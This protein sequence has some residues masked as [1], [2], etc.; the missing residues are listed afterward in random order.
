M[1]KFR[2]G[3]ADAAEMLELLSNYQVDERGC[4]IWQ[5][6]VDRNGYGR[7]YDPRRGRMYWVHIV[8][9][10]IHKGPVP[11]GHEVDHV[12]RTPQCMH[13]DHLEAVTKVE[14]A[15]RTFERLGRD[16]LH[17][18]AAELR[19]MNLTYREIGEVMGLAGKSS[20]AGMIKSAARKGLIREGDVPPARKITP[21]ERDD[22]RD[23]YA[24]GVPQT[25]LGECYGLHSSQVS[26]ICSGR[27]S[28]HR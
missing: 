23:L 7:V 13:P 2:E 1:G 26:R 15:R 19:R 25:V 12:C 28:G 6:Y 24:F 16:G 11:E 4:R 14:H 20:A 22:I 5:G 17:L 10:E 9:H 21:P 3:A 27:T 18:M 8:S